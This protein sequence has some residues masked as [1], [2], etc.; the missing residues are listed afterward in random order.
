MIKMRKES[1]CITTSKIKKV[2]LDEIEKLYWLNMLNGEMDLE[3]KYG[4]DLSVSKVWQIEYIVY[5]LVA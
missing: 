2:P 1:E 4:A 5:F 3:V